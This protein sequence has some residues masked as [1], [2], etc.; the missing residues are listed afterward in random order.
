MS[1]VSG[2]QPQTC[3]DSGPNLASVGCQGCHF[4]SGLGKVFINLQIICSI[5]S[6]APPPIEKSLKSIRYFCFTLISL[7]VAAWCS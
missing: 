7:A 6:S 4:L 2:G 1:G 5:T 3:Q